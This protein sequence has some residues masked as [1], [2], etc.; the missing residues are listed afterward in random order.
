MQIDIF[1]EIQFFCNFIFYIFAQA[2]CKNVM[3]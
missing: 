1:V 3:N 2:L